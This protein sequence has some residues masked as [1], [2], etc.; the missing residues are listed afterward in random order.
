MGTDQ[1]FGLPLP[2]LSKW[3]ERQTPRV[4]D[5]KTE[6]QVIFFCLR[7]CSQVTKIIICKV[8]KKKKT[9]KFKK[10]HPQF[11]PV[12]NRLS[13]LIGCTC[14]SILQLVLKV[15]CADVGFPVDFNYK[16]T[17]LLRG[18]LWKCQNPVPRTPALRPGPSESR[19][20]K[21]N[22]S[23]PSY[24]FLKLFQDTASKDP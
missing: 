2:V 9:L 8:L 4:R 6:R 21:S 15:G 24:L 12:R 13:L 20:R 17:F 19:R 3:R 16:Q 11:R 7:K 23:L 14:F 1:I 5:R 22:G 10:M 18:S